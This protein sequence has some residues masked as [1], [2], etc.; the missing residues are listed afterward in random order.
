MTKELFKKYLNNS[1]SS[2][3]VEEVIHWMKEQ[4]FYDESLKFG[5]NDWQQF[6]EENSNVS[7]EKLEILLDKIHH[8]LNIEG[9]SPIQ[10]N[11]ITII[12]WVTRAAAILLIPVLAFLF[13]TISENDKFK[14]QFAYV[15]VDSL[16]VIAPVGSRT[17]VELSDGTV[18]HLNYG[19][20]IKYP[21]NFS[22]E[23][24][25]V[26][27]TGEGYFEVAHN[28]G[29]PFV[30][31]TGLVD[32]KAIGTVFNV[33]A[34][35]ENNDISTTLVEG[36]VVLEVQ[37][38]GNNYKQ[39]GALK[40]GQHVNYNLKTGNLISS[41]GNVEKHIGWKDGKLVFDNDSIDLVARRLSRM[42][43]V[44]IQVENDVKE[45]KY[46]VTFVDEPLFQ[47]LE[48][49]TIATPIKYKTFP[50]TKNPDGTFSK[51]KII[52]ERNQ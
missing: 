18:A 11:R 8:K 40:P 3:E 36:K 46:T 32:V 28:P 22:G 42:F 35:P 10:I 17:V 20:R 23:T 48:L 16:E 2:Q 21:Q 41:A 25:C 19:S 6:K 9:S 44:D 52:I 5:K 14:N 50:R 38:P 26:A 12:G 43:N 47:I 4:S 30:V 7:D 13:Y 33:N 51:Q 49:L 1:C 39:L 24:R 31:T 29:K 45:F 37:Q 27:L 34:Y 15:T